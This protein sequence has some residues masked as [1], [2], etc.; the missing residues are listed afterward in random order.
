[1]MP[2]RVTCGFI[3]CTVRQWLARLCC[4]VLHSLLSCCLASLCHLRL[5]VWRWYMVFIVSSLYQPLP[6]CVF[7]IVLCV[8]STELT[9]IDSC[10]SMTFSDHCLPLRCDGSCPWVLIATLSCE[11]PRWFICLKLFWCMSVCLSV[12]LSVDDMQIGFS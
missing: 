12:C 9:C 4:Q 1:M 5:R 10:H 2:G 6:L 3:Y 11:K 8:C 7:Y